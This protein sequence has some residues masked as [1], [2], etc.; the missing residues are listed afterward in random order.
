VLCNDLDATGK[1]D[2]R[3]K[4]WVC[5]FCFELVCAFACQLK[6]APGVQVL[7]NDLK[8]SRATRHMLVFVG[9]FFVKFLVNTNRSL[10]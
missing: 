4:M 2:A 5:G 7:C 8:S 9:W 3:L 10:G 6:A 1:Q